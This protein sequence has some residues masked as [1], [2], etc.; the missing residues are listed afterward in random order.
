M[1]V[2]SREGTTPAL[3]RDLRAGSI[4]IALLASAPS[5]R[6]PDDESPPL[7]SETLTERALCLAVP[8]EHPPARG[9]FVDVADL[10]G[11]QWIAASPS[12]TDRLM[13]VWPGLDERP[14]IVHTARDRLA[15]RHLV[16]AGCGLTTVPAGLAA[17]APPGVR[18]LPVRGGPAGAAASAAGA[19]PRA[20]ARARR[21]PRGRPADRRSGR[22]LGSLTDGRG[23]PG[24]T[25]CVT[26]GPRLGGLRGRPGR[27]RPSVCPHP[28]GDVGT[29]M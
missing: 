21:P 10:R 19:A 2:V 3:A 14:E 15:K 4:D 1:R 28:V 8:A 24:R 12:G 26:P 20:D 29:P 23:G 27:R 18:V 9:E 7:A 16:A 11:Q 17:A 13:G 6:A 5:F 25:W 22:R